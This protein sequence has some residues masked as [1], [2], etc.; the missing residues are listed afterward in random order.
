[1]LGNRGEL[2]AIQVDNGK[3][4]WET[5]VDSF[6]S[7][8]QK[9]LEKQLA[10]AKEGKEILRPFIDR[11][12]NSGLAYADGV[13]LVPSSIQAGS[14][15]AYDAKSGKKLWQGGVLAERSTP[16]VANIDGHSII[17]VHQTGNEKAKTSGKIKALDPKTG[18]VLWEEA[19]SNLRGNPMVLDGDI[20]ITHSAGYKLSKQGAKKLYDLPGQV[21][22][23]AAAT[24]CGGV[25]LVRTGDNKERGPATNWTIDT[26][27]GEVIHKDDRLS[28]A[29][30]EAHSFSMS[31]RFI[32]EKDS[33]HGVIQWTQ[34]PVT[35][36]YKQ[37]GP[38]ASP[39]FAPTTAYSVPV[40]YALADGRMWIR[41]NNGLYCLDLRAK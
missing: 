7:G 34:V 25:A 12:F 28:L 4:L 14:L 35:G 6:H 39:P 20:L 37:I 5:R 38:V 17:I 36:E 15:I 21:V 13:V 30:D 31:G 26:S 9:A 2:R 18:E 11:S 10:A 41:S 8:T 24:I 22:Y 32:M 40:G 33:Q 1:V 23:R 29:N 19:A 16:L 3:V 27:S